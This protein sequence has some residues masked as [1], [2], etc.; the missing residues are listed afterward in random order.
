M[1]NDWVYDIETFPNVFT[2]AIEHAE[3]PIKLSY[4]I[5]DWRNES[6]EILQFLQYLQSTGARMVGFNNLGFDYP[7]IHLLWHMRGTATAKV[8]YDKAMAIIA[9]Q[10]TDDVERWDHHIWPSDR[11]VPQ[12][13][14]YKIHHFDNKAKSTGLKALQFAMR[15]DTLE[16]L[17]FPVGTTLDQSQVEMLKQ[18]NMHD[19]HAT[20]QFYHHTTAQIAFREQLMVKHPGKDWLN[21]ND[22]KI[23]KEFFTLRLTEAGVACYEEGAGG[24]KP[25]QTRRDVI[26]LRDA[27]LPVIEFEQPELQRV[28]EWLKG[29]SITETK[30]VFTDLTATIPQ[31]KAPPFTFVFGLGGVHGSVKNQIIESTAEEIIVDLDVSSYYPTLAIANKFYPAHLGDEFCKIYKTL[32]M[33][34]RSYPKKSAESAM[35]KLALNGVYGDSNNQF[36]VFYD[37][38]YTM[39]ITINGQLLLCKLAENILESIDGAQLLQVNTDGLTVK[40]PRSREEDLLATTLVWEQS[41]DLRLEEARYQKMFIRDVNNYLA[42]YEDGR[43]KRK[44]AYD[45]E[46]EWHKDHSALVVPKVVEKVL[47]EGAPIRQTL[48]EWS[49]TMDFMMMV[50]VPRNSYLTAEKDGGKPR[51]LQNTTRYYVAKGGESLFK[52]MPPL[53]TNPNW[54][55]MGVQAGWGV[56]VCNDIRDAEK[57]PVDI[58][59]YVEEVEKLCLILG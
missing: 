6:A 4:E 13:D 10:S 16:D 11:V 12:I 57:L 3:A 51:Q 56:Q 58:N 36:S 41:Y 34:R 18:Y 21:F 7:V 46:K 24:K 22:T 27:V 8:L 45:W 23:G 55:K 32:Y 43:V 20:K 5:S 53:K 19:V 59:F 38:L 15:L 30:G 35:L 48:E 1:K 17:P 49:N 42:V 2:I 33:Q 28:C 39:Q 29:Q 54:R 40:I 14:L 47:I 31:Q 52:W 37:P 9:S 44:G 50:K 25:R 26:H